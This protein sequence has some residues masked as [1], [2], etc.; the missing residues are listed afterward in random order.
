MKNKYQS[1]VTTYIVVET[2]ILCASSGAQYISPSGSLESINKGT[3][4]W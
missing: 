3:S 1:P 4:T 2:S